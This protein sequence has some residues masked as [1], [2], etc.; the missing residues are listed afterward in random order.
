MSPRHR[1]VSL[2][3]A[4][5]A[6]GALGPATAPAA[7]ANVELLRGTV[8]PA[9]HEARG[10]ATVVARSDGSRTLN[11]R[12]F[13][14]DPGPVVRVWLVPKRARSDG[15]I[16]DDYRDLGRLKGSKGNQSYRIPKSVD[17][18]KYSSVVFWCV[19]FTSNL[20]RADLSR[21]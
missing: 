14:I 5:V 17:L 13:R 10:V 3:L 6:A 4:G 19:P 21:S 15:R 18:R 20:A 1:S 7:A 8:R 16:D 12:R 9:S 11:L 2:L